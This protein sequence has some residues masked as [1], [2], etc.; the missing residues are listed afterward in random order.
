MTV[1]GLKMSTGV[2]D[3]S[4]T[5]T[6]PLCP[7]QGVITDLKLVL[8]CLGGTDSVRVELAPTSMMVTMGQKEGVNVWVMMMGKKE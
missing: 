1:T 7:I 6:Y 2:K 8:F 4:S 3:F 5:F